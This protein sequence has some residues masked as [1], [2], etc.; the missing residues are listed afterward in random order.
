MQISGSLAKIFLSLLSKWKEYFCGCVWK[1]KGN[2]SFKNELAQLYVIIFLIKCRQEVESGLFLKSQ[3][4]ANMSELLTC[5][6]LYDP[7]LKLH[8]GFVTVSSFETSSL[9]CK[10]EKVIFTYYFLFCLVCSCRWTPSLAYGLWNDFSCPFPLSSVG[11]TE[12]NQITFCEFLLSIL[13]R[14]SLNCWFWSALLL[15]QL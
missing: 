1:Q 6:S 12:S 11:C 5:I 2:T 3:T 13:S 8:K 9:G 4:P 15:L 10:T 7:S 14:S